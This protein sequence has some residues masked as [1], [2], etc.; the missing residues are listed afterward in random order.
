M[1]VGPGRLVLKE[2]LY[3]PEGFGPSGHGQSCVLTPLAWAGQVGTGHSKVLA[4]LR[5]ETG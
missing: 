1:M 2:K 4:R 3:L 5:P